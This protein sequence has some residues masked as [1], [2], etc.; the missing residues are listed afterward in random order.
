MSREVTAQADRIFA[1]AACDG[2]WLV[3]DL[4]SDAMVGQREHEAQVAASTFKVF[5]AL[6][7]CLQA[8]G[9]PADSGVYEQAKRMMAVSDNLSTDA[10][11]A[12]VG[13]DRINGRLQALGLSDS[14]VTGDVKFVTDLLAVDLGFSTYEELL[15]AQRGEF[16]NEARVRATDRTAIARSRAVA[17]EHTI[18]SSPRDMVRL[19]RLVWRDRVAPAAA[20]AALREL[21]S[22]QRSERI[23]SKLP[24]EYR[25]WA[26]SGTLFGVALNEVGVV[27][28][29]S[30]RELA[31]AMFTRM[32]RPFEHQDRAAAAIGEVTALA[33]AHLLAN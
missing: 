32:H 23:G 4:D 12:K 5:V 6:E 2:S 28:T 11:I 31:V 14:M 1:A 3:A 16:G 20:C 22:H 15:R 25:V 7:L 19:L 17:L 13:L 27:G 33:I 30:G 18:T 8:G 24:A 26:K 21:M 29:P 10:L 9:R